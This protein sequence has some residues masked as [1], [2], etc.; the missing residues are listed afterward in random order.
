[1]RCLFHSLSFWLW[2]HIIKVGT[3]QMKKKKKVCSFFNIFNIFNISLSATLLLLSLDHFLYLMYIRIIP[4][5][6]VLTVWNKDFHKRLRKSVCSFSDRIAVS[7]FYPCRFSLLFIAFST[8]HVHRHI[9]SILSFTLGQSVTF[10]N[11]NTTKF[12]YSQFKIL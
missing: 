7:L 3:K 10:H 5:L 6:S 2:R 8:S 12:H 1:M 11:H 9:V 4:T